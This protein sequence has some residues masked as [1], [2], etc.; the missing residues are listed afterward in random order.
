MHCKEIASSEFERISSELNSLERQS[1]P[2]ETISGHHDRHGW[3]VLLRDASRCMVLF[4]SLDDQDLAQ[5]D[6]T[7]PPPE[8]VVLE[9]AS[10]SSEP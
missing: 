7:L 6:G 9:L 4:D 10:M 3:T 2:I 1:G 5:A 8:G